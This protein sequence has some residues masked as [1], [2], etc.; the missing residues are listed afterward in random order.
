MI[1]RIVYS[2]PEGNTS[3]LS[4]PPERLV[5]SSASFFAMIAL[6]WLGAQ[7]YERRAVLCAAAGCAASA[8]T[9]PT[10]ATNERNAVMLILLQRRAQFRKRAES[11]S[12]RFG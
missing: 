1:C 10:A 11:L 7:W 12:T 6:S 3:T 4:L 5:T 8:A 9:K 2:C